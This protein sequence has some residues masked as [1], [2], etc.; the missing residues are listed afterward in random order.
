MIVHSAT[1]E[2]SKWYKDPE[3]VVS[4]KQ[5]VK[6][7]DYKLDNMYFLREYD[8]ALRLALSELAAEETNVGKDGRE[9]RLLDFGMRCCIKLGRSETGVTLARKSH[10]YVR[11]IPQEGS[12]RICLTFHSVGLCSW[13]RWCCGRSIRLLRS[14]RWCA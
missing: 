10:T 3:V 11:I 13:T 9:H 14:P 12:V 4:D 6:D 7:V 2:R 8:S 1:Y 5:R